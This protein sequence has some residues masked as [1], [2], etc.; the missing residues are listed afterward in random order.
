MILVFC[1]GRSRTNAGSVERGG[2]II[3]LLGDVFSDPA[4]RATA[5]G[6]GTGQFVKD[7]VAR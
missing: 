6:T 3:E 5:V 2:H 1:D 7:L 4:H